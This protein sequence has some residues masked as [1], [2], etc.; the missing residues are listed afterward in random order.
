M[1]GSVS[2]FLEQIPAS[3]LPQSR[4]AAGWG[5]FHVNWFDLRRMKLNL[6]PYVPFLTK[7]TEEQNDTSAVESTIR[8]LVEYSKERAQSSP[9]VFVTGTALPP[10]LAARSDLRQH[11]IVLFDSDA[12][13]TFLSAK[14]PSARYQALGRAMARCIGPS[15]LS[16]YVPGKPAS[17]GRFFGRTGALGQVVAGKSI[18]NCTIVGNR[19]IGKTSLLHEVREQLAEVYAP[20]KSI[21]FADVYANKCK[22]TWDMVYLILSQLGVSVPKNYSKL[23]AIAPRFVTRFPQL[24]H[25]HARRTQMQL[26]ILIDEF[27]S[28]LELDAKQDWAFLHLL[29]EAAAEDNNCAVII[30]GFRLLMQMR[31]LQGS[32]YYNFTHEVTLTPLHK[33]ETLEMVNLPLSRLGIDLAGTN[34][35]TVIHKETRGHP[36]IIQM[37]CQTIIQFYEKS[38]RLP[39]EAELLKNVNAD[40]AFNR[41]ILHTFLNNTNTW[42]QLVCLRLMKRAVECGRDVA[43]Y[44]FRVAD[45]TDVLNGMKVPLSNAEMAT[46][47]TNLVVGSFI[48]RAKGAPG[49]YHFANPQL[50]RFC[51]EIGF[52]NLIKNVPVKGSGEALTFDPGATGRFDV[53]SA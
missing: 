38:G 11:S 26:V 50:V 30:A 16:P 2:A 14:D 20:G 13:R 52:D 42:E 18:R 15:S 29:R 1:T 41:T 31:V 24:I 35:A 33:E 17:G 7:G 6:G 53:S 48:E 43:S 44:E 51:Q 22:S 8:E 19:R 12:I 36:E 23:G 4:P 3:R 49:Q 39:S 25:E 32:P 46:L 40:S 34:L 21:M 37:Y 45:V 5:S 27:D 10:G 47:L 28:F 9:V